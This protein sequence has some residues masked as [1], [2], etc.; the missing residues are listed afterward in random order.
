MSILVSP[1]Q[2]SVEQCEVSFQSH[3]YA[4]MLLRRANRI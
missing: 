4:Q 2:A 3:L 1:T